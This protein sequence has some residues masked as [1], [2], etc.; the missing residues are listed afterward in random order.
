MMNKMTLSSHNRSN[1]EREKHKA[2]VRISFESISG[3]QMVFVS[4]D[5]TYREYIE[6]GRKDDGENKSSSIAGMA[7][8]K[9][10]N[11]EDDTQ[12]C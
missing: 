11:D 1:K 8:D 7:H 4:R 12:N 9:S 6:S 5:G 2:I 10:D 3:K